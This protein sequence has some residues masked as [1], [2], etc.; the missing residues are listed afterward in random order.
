MTGMGWIGRWKG[1]V[2]LAI[3]LAMLLGRMAGVAQAGERLPLPEGR[4]EL[5]EHGFAVAWDPEVWRGTSFDESYGAGIHLDND[6]SQGLIQVSWAPEPYPDGCVDSLLGQWQANYPDVVPAPRSAPLPETDIWGSQALFRARMSDEGDSDGT[7]MLY[8]A[9]KTID[10]GAGQIMIEFTAPVADYEEERTAWDE[11][12]AAITVEQDDEP[13]PWIAP[14]PASGGAT[15]RGEGYT[16]A[17]DDDVWTTEEYL[18]GTE[19]SAGN[20][21]VYAVAELLPGDADAGACLDETDDGWWTDWAY[22]FHDEAPL[23]MRRPKAPET[24]TGELFSARMQLEAKRMFAVYVE[25][26]EVDGGT[27]RIHFTTTFVGWAGELPA[28]QTLL[29]GIDAGTAPSSGRGSLGKQGRANDADEGATDE[30]ALVTVEGTHLAFTSAY[31]P[32]LWTFAAASVLGND[33]FEL[34]NEYGEVMVIGSPA[35]ADVE[36]CLASLQTATEWRSTAGATEAAA[37]IERPDVG[38][39][40]VDSLLTYTAEIDGATSEQIA[41]LVC[42]PAGGGHVSLTF[43]GPASGYV[44]VLPMLNDLLAG[45]D[46]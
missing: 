44:E 15:Y 31:D 36:G 41:Y 14:D 16:V 35:D 27:L 13:E 3:V 17:Y 19:F 22:E 5:P 37:S 23:S 21:Q 39:D 6:V 10:S 34:L 2:A 26:R 12:F 11:V 42:M 32:A 40:A 9:C 43:Y 46:F 24:A 45:L 20:R 29:D 1:R 28:I 18:D 33:V 38:R 8:L 4:F 25:C 7:L 30:P